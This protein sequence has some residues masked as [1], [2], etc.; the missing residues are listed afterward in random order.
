MHLSAKVLLQAFYKTISS[1]MPSY[2][3]EVLSDFH[4]NNDFWVDLNVQGI[5]MDFMIEPGTMDIGDPHLSK[6]GYFVEAAN[7][8]V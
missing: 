3:Q 6:R 2:L 7:A 1:C 8:D 5:M 4:A